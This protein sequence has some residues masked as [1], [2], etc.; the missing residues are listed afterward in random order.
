MSWTTAGFSGKPCVKQTVV[1]H[2]DHPAM[3]HMEWNER[4]E[5][6]E[7]CRPN[8]P[9]FLNVEVQLSE[10]CYRQILGRETRRRESV[11]I[12]LS[13]IADSGCQTTLAG[14]ELLKYLDIDP[15]SDLFKTKHKIRG[16]TETSVEIEGALML[17]V[18]Y[19]G[20]TSTQMVY[21]SSNTD[22]FFLSMKALKDLE[23][24]DKDFPE[25][26]MQSRVMNTQVPE[27]ENG[28]CS[29]PKRSPAPERVSEIPYPPV[30]ENVGKLKEWILQR[31][32]ASAFNRCTYQELNVM[33]G[34]PMKINFKKGAI[35]Y[36]VHTPIRV[37]VHW[38]EKMK[39]DIDRDVR[40]GI[41]EEVPQGTPTTHCARMVPQAK[42]NGDPR[43]TIDMQKLKEITLRETHHTPSP[44]DVVSS[45]PPN[46]YKTVADAWNGY[47]S[48][49]LAEESK[50]ATTFI[51]QWGRYR[52]RRAPQGFH[53]SG[54]AYTRR[55][56]DITKAFTNVSRVVD[57][58]LLHDDSIESAFWHACDYL[59]HCSDNGIIFNADKLV[60]AQEECEFAGFELTKDGYRPPNRI[61]EAIR[62]FPTP[63]CPTDVRSWFGLINQVAYAFA[64]A[65]VMAAFRELM[66][67]RSMKSWYWDDVLTNVF[68]KSKQ[69]IVESI[70]EGV[71]AFEKERTT[72]LSTDW[73]K[74][75]I[76]FALLQK[77]CH[78]KE[79]NPNCGD[80]HWKLVY[81]GSRFTKPAET[82]Y[83]PIEGETLAVVYGLEQCKMFILGCPKLVIAVDH[84]PLIN[85]L[86]DRALESIDNP[87]VLR[88]KEKTL[89]YNFQIVY[90]PGKK[91]CLADI[92]SR[93]PSVAA[94]SRCDHTS[95]TDIEENANAFAITTTKNLPSTISWEKVNEEAALDETCAMLKETIETGFPERKDELPLGVRGFW[96]MRN[97]LYVIGNTLFLGKKM[98]IPLSLR[99][100]ILNGLHAG[101]QGVSSMKAAARQRFFWPG[102]DGDITQVRAQCRSCNQIAPSQ[103]P[104]RIMLT[105]SPDLPFEKVAMDPCQIA[106]KTYLVY[107][108]RFSGWTEVAL[109]KSTS[110]SDV[111]KE[112]LAWFRSYGVPNEISSD[113]GPPF[114]SYEFENFLKAWGV[115]FRKSSAYYAQSNGRA[116]AAVKVVKRLLMDNC[117]KVTGQINT[118]A[119]TR[120]LMIHRNTPN[121][122]TGM[123]P[124]ELLFGRKMRDHLPNCFRQMRTEF[125]EARKVK[126]FRTMRR[127]A[128]TKNT[129]REYDQLD[130]GDPVSIQDQKGNRPKRWSSTGVV[131]E[132]LPDRKYHVLVDGS[133]RMTTR[134]RRFLRRIKD[135]CRD[136]QFPAAPIPPVRTT[137]DQNRCNVKATQQTI[138][139]TKTPERIITNPP[140]TPEIKVRDMSCIA[141]ERPL[142]TSTPNRQTPNGRAQTSADVTPRLDQSPLQ[143]S[144]PNRRART[145][146]D[147]TPGPAISLEDARTTQL[148]AVEAPTAD[149]T[150]RSE[151]TPPLRRSTRPKT[152]SKKF[153]DFVV[154][155]PKKTKKVRIQ[156][157]DQP[158]RRSDR[159]KK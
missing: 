5:R 147:V 142:Q 64:Q 115:D 143:R 48:L 34:E 8:P 138:Q 47:H 97:D 29:C 116:E 93:L 81:T 157:P 85:I 65:P 103:T 136:Y 118:E 145:S 77:Y 39:A 68:E 49:L 98:L 79:D 119:A 18:M 30:K 101:H 41:L 127:Q 150:L 108:D 132:V 13:S 19:N 153:E 70:K 27:C 95:D 112:L 37:P 20:R 102:L 80:G 62:N 54:D 36:A 86:N 158:V 122:V 26:T 10:K 51:T 74:N 114:N 123:C 43:R 22:G 1:K 110:F 7:R 120:A 155:I 104:E 71:K 106:G 94:E 12:K 4:L 159:L 46:T 92:M 66:T 137:E 50:D 16:I 38:E 44:H 15:K 90:V 61:I 141:D 3:A 96:N 154:E 35:P 78:C 91:N 17:D 126:E 25:V 87:R 117:D 151:G 11:P 69:V 42:K 146:V 63:T 131:T 134:N 53:A 73:S 129:D 84:K 99:K 156:L 113:G 130:I 140:R 23:I 149:T 128:R 45:I 56:D 6:M 148:L 32:A 76:G 2:I 75:G 52:Y 9:P 33:T 82:R 57:D 24:I 67:K 133:R 31:Y 60:F 14:V 111:K 89:R 100:P 144:T 107:A 105:P 21:V 72:C 139:N 59:K 55:F 121:Q 83:A 124:S 135:G 152:M 88:L 40:L 125:E 58:S 109:L 28:K